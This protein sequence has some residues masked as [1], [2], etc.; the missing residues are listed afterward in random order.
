MAAIEMRAK[1]AEV[2]RQGSEDMAQQHGWLNE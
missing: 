2:N 1:V